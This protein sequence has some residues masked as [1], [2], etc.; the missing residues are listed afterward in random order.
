LIN[1]RKLILWFIVLFIFS[2]FLMQKVKTDNRL[3]QSKTAI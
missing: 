3:D 1:A 2:C